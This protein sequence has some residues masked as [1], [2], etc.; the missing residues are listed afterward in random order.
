MRTVVYARLAVFVCCG[1]LFAQTPPDAAQ[2]P[3]TPEQER[4]QQIRQFDPLYRPDDPDK[5]KA[6]KEAEKRRQQED[7]PTPGSIADSQ[8][9]PP[10][11]SGPQVEDDTADNQKQEYSGPAVLSRSYSINQLVTPKQLTW[12]ESV[13]VSTS[14]DV[15]IGQPGPN[16][17]VG[18]G[19]TLQ[20][21]TVNW[22]MSGGHT[23]GHDTLHIGYAGS[24]AYY[25]DS[26][27]YTGAN[28]SL[29]ATYAHVV[30]RRI[31]LG[32]SFS[33]SVF[34]ANAALQS[35]AVGPETIANA[36]LATSPSIAIFDT[37]SKQMNI[38]ANLGWQLNSR[39]SFTYSGSY[40]GVERNSAALLGVSGKQAGASGNYRLT[41]K[42]TIGASYSYS[43]YVYPHGSETS[44]VQS[45]SLIYSYALNRSTQVRFNGG[46][47]R[48]ESLGLQVVPINPIIAALLGVSSGV[49]DAYQS[50]RGTNVSAQLIHD[51]RK[52]RTASFSYAR[53]I[54]PGNGL[55]QTSQQ[56]TMSLSGGARIFRTYGLSA[57]LSRDSLTSLTQNVGQYRTETAQLSIS[58]AY[59][60]G[61]GVNFSI[62]YSYFEIASFASLR[63]QLFISSGFSWSSA[64]LWPF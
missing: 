46:L 17:A 43:Q 47:S 37:G 25:P 32:M 29:S 58:R 54:T 30:S 64:R 41:R 60:K 36:N 56:E 3:L 33:G 51:F 35:P 22:S 19:G 14:H 48:E 53:G 45:V 9:P 6:D 10:Q 57:R 16:G 44:D 7:S 27:L 50:Y 28:H 31:S 34:S 15:G 49:I 40:F 52:G 24:M 63:N 20:G 5:V 26:S 39:L 21:T 61:V 59:K 1:G 38:G 2:T 13:G 11:R 55:S 62:N 8:T 18:A 23:F 42:T 12:S 4:E